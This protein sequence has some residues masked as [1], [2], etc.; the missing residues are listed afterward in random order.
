MDREV[1]LININKMEGIILQE[2]LTKGITIKKQIR[3]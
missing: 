2:V 1:S 3:F